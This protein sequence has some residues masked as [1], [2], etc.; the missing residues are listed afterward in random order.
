MRKCLRRRRRRRKKDP[1]YVCAFVQLSDH[2]YNRRVH[3]TAIR[4]Q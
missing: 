2:A 4:I 3:C 1:G